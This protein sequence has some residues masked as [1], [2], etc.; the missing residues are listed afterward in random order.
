[1]NKNTS[2]RDHNGTVVAEKLSLNVSRF[3]A[4]YEQVLSGRRPAKVTV[5]QVEQER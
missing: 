2:T 4:V 1:M 5:Q 3:V